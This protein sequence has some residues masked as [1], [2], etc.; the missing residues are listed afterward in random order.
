MMYEFFFKKAFGDEREPL[1]YQLRLAESNHWPDI[2]NIPTGLGKTAAVT[3]AW[4]YRKVEKNE[5]DMPRRLVWCLPMRVLV[6]QTEENIRQWLKNLE[7]DDIS[8]HVIM[9]GSE[10]VLKPTWASHP[11][12]LSILIGTQDMLLSRA[13]MRGYGMSRYQWPVHFSQLHNDALWV[14]DEV[15]LMGPAL[16]TTAQL[17]AFRRKFQIAKPCRS[18]WVS[19]T[20][21]ADWLSTVD[22]KHYIPDFT[23]ER[24]TED[25]FINPV[26]TQRTKSKKILNNA[27]TSL[28]KENSKEK[29]KEYIQKLSA[30][31]RIKHKPDT[32]TLVILNQV[33]RA[34]SL[35]QALVKE[36][37]STELLL[38]HARFRP[39]ERRVIENRLKETGKDRIIIATQAIEA[40]VD[41][42]STTLFS[43]LAPWSSLVQR[44]GRCNRYGENSESFIF[45]I[46]IDEEE[47]PLPY[48]AES[49]ESSRKQI[50]IILESESKNTGPGFLPVVNDELLSGLVLRRRDFLELF[51]TDAD[52]SG[53]DIDISPYIRDMGVPSVQVFWRDFEN[54]DDELPPE[55]QELCPAGMSQINQHLKKD[56]DKET[57]AWIWDSIEDKWRDLRI[58]ELRPGLVLMLKASDGGY[59]ENIGFQAKINK[60]KVTIVQSEHTGEA[61]SYNG[62]KL[63]QI[64]RFVTLA[65]HLKDAK[66]EAE[67]LCNALD[68]QAEII[69]PVCFASERHDVGKSHKAFQHSITCKVNPPESEVLWAKSANQNQRII[70]MM[71]PENGQNKGVQRKH[72]RHEL[73]SMLS[74]LENEKDNPDRDLIAYLIAAHHGKVRMGLGAMPNEKK[75]DKDILFARGIWDGDILPAVRLNEAETIPETTLHLDLMQIGDGPMGPSWSARTHDLL[76]KYGP[77]RLAWMETLVRI[78]D[79]RASEKEK[80]E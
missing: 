24:L 79:W 5:K 64:G 16:S 26:V 9:G 18:T 39:S 78:A 68:E 38:L 19:A 1:P 63:S 59:D 37:K 54:A 13:L 40:G 36:N 58:S 50:K 46:N 23:I 77:F 57:K 20:L 80:G 41:I 66:E 48:N 55:R 15:Q 67:K 31:I 33:D 75:P 29:C 42:S 34:Q 22:L 53:F 56:K 52:L 71:P 28:S 25:D 62:D 12:K 49:L 51:N 21:K 27:D 11:E 60:N 65:D 2:I 30:E 3:L 45:L 69:A 72:F 4:L 32:Q 76:E 44:F 7:Y 8:V 73:A 14:Y 61:E 35:Y 74:W 17:E 6:E 43:E 70:Y 10:D 47:Q